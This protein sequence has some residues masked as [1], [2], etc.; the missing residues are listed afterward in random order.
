MK[1]RNRQCAVTVRYIP[2]KTNHWSNATLSHSAG[3]KAA[4]VETERKGNS[5][6]QK[7]RLKVNC[8]YASFQYRFYPRQINQSINGIGFVDILCKVTE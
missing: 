6:A 5:L 7:S 4:T 8:F 2:L 3:R 1:D